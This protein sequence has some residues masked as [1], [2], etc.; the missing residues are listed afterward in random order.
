MVGGK[1]SGASA[2]DFTGFTLEL[3]N[4]KTQWRS[5]KIALRADGVFMVNLHAEKGER[6]TFVIEL[7]DIN[8]RKQKIQPD[9]LTYTIGVGGDVE[10]PLINSMGIA[11][12]NNEYDKLFEKGRGLPLKATRDYRTIHPIRQGQT[13]EL[14]RIPIIEGENALADRNRHVDDL[15]IE[16]AN[17]RR[18][19][20]AG[21][22][23][24][25]TLR[26]DESRLITASAYVPFLDEEFSKK[27][28]LRHKNADAEFLNK[29]FDNEM[30]RFQ[31]VKS[32]AVSVDGET[33]GEMVQQVEDSPLMQDVEES[34]AAAQADHNAA[35]KCEKRLLELKLKLDEA[36][37]ALEWP[38]L[39]SESRDWLGYLHKVTDQ[40]G[41]NQQKQKGD[42]LTAE[43]EQIIRE[44]KPDR[45]R[46]KIEHIARLYYEIIMAQ[47]GW[48][49]Y[50]FQQTEKEEQKM[51]D[52][53]RAARLLDQGR[54]CIA[55][56]NFTGLQNVV[57]Q[58]WDLLPDETVEE[59]KRGYGATI[60]R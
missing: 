59:A 43:V 41:N 34:L 45:L 36:A 5:G 30:R 46:K 8:G 22:E 7:Y 57:R 24:E 17:I 32:K 26:I 47:P 15:L 10:Q 33:A 58:L 19:L 28:E 44:H 9:A 21:S 52:Q 11:L 42:E 23:L 16:A 12:A 20:P 35:A 25:V 39:V 14:I 6:N 29:D 54:D 48:W 13:G 40:H 51:K 4:T 50:Q 49:V 2:Q 55:K 56:N 1:I 31:E 37:D 27:I 3:V 53:D 60:I 38:A 18:D